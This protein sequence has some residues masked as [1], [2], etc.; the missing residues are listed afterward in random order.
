MTT[1]IDP[2]VIGDLAGAVAGEQ[3]FAAEA[4]AKGTTPDRLALA[5]LSQKVAIYQAGSGDNKTLTEN[6]RK[7]AAYAQSPDK[8]MA[9]FS[10][11]NAGR[12]TAAFMSVAAEASPQEPEVFARNAIEAI[13]NKNVM[14]AAGIKPQD[15]PFMAFKK[16]A[17]AALKRS[18]DQNI[19]LDKALADMGIK[20]QRARM[21]A[22]TMVT[23]G[24]RGGQFAARQKV[25]DE[26]ATPEQAEAKIA[27]EFA[28]TEGPIPHR[29]A[30]QGKELE[31]AKRGKETA[32]AMTLREQ[33][34]ARLIKDRAETTGAGEHAWN[35]TFG[36]IEQAAGG[37]PAQEV[38]RTKMMREIIE[39]RA[40]TQGVTLPE[41]PQHIGEGL[42]NVETARARER[43]L[44][45][46]EGAF[47]S[48][49]GDM[50][51]DLT[52]KQVEIQKQQLDEARK[53]RELA[54]KQAPMP[55]GRVNTGPMGMAR[56]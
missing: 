39:R 19:P 16:L 9:A 50:L 3:D 21:A 49:G 51:L 23:K 14:A 38:R 43:Y 10:G 46:M 34:E 24:V 35:Y 13:R 12:D 40:K 22:A 6:L 42:L 32:P 41:Y 27:A 2:K 54:G 33:V 31:A 25:G 15:D 44:K 30:V 29:L 18:Q 7:F 52:K 4:K 45:D 20:N 28:N 55:L 1:G 8:G 17:D 47:K 36:A 37:L 11:P 53:A 26:Y 48:Q 56:P 5:A